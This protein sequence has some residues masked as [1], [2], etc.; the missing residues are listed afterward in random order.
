MLSPLYTIGSIIDTT[1][2][3]WYYVL[4]IT[5]KEVEIPEIHLPDGLYERLG[6]WAQPFESPA[7]VIQRLLEKMENR[8]L[9]RMSS[10]ADAG[11]HRRPRDNSLRGAVIRRWEEEDQPDWNLED[12]IRVSEEADDVFLQSGENPAPKFRQERNVG[13]TTYVRTW[14][15]GCHFTWLN[16]R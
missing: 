13:N 2:C 9:P 4:G 8:R 1:G 12:T 7:D 3:Q 16:P 11:R 5:I 14:V 10:R 6:R 15:Y